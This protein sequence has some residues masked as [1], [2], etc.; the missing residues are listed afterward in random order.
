MTTRIGPMPI[1]PEQL[2]E[3]KREGP[4]L[5]SDPVTTWEGKIAPLIAEVERLREVLRLVEWTCAAP[6]GVWPACPACG[7]TPPS[8]YDVAA[9]R[10][11]VGRGHAPDCPLATALR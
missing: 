9:K 4:G 5:A 11:D 2:A 10:A 1:T 7:G 3:W 6:G 8:D